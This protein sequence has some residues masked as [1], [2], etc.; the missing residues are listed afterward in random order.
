MGEALREIAKEFTSNRIDLFGKEPDIVGVALVSLSAPMNGHKV[1]YPYSKSA[2]CEKRLENVSCSAISS[3]GRECLWRREPEI[4][5]LSTVDQ[6]TEDG[7]C[8]ET[9]RAKPVNG[10][11]T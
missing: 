11:V 8:I 9:P 10:T 5:A 7:G 6:A 4:A 3:P 1:S 2:G